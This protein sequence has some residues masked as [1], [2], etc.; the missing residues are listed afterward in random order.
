MNNP[1]AGNSSSGNSNPSVELEPG[2]IVF[3]VI[4]STLY[5][6]YVEE[7]LCTVINRVK[8]SVVGITIVTDEQKIYGS[9]VV[10]G[11]SENDG[12]SYV[13]TSHD[14]VR[15]AQSVTVVDYLT[16]ETYSGK[17]VGTDPLT[18]I[19]V[20][21]IDAVLTPAIFCPEEQP[22]STGMKVFSLANVLGSQT[23]VASDGIVS[24]TNFIYDVG[25]GKENNLFLTNI[26]NMQNL[27]GGGIF[28]QK[29]GFLIGMVR[30]GWEE[31]MPSFA[32]S[33]SELL[34]VS[35][36]LVEYGFV[37]GRYKFGIQLEDNKGSWGITESVEV[38]ALEEDGLLY[39]NNLGLKVGD[40]LTSVI[41]NGETFTIKQSTDLF[42]CLYEYDFEIGDKITFVVQRNGTH[43]QITVEVVQYSYFK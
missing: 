20:L 23:L 41:V 7:E 15:K 27:L 37:K 6:Q 1:P 26:T 36:Q 34:Q 2:D 39:A 33:A 8:S 3:S 31:G 43:A 40:Y 19:C 35:Q 38:T 13:S 4:D 32:I 29:G 18:D 24:A 11:A 9:G 22:I 10:I 30:S 28:T 5:S 42:D 17:P 25:E 14:L 16:G 12:R 21:E